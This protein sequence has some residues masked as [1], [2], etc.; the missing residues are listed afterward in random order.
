MIN[1]IV[2]M[3]ANKIVITAGLSAAERSGEVESIF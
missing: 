3:N 1:R 2:V